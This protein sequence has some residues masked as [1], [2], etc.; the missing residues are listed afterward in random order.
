MPFSRLPPPP[1]PPPSPLTHRQA[2]HELAR[3]LKNMFYLLYH[4]IISHITGLWHL[5]FRVQIIQLL[6]LLLNNHLSLLF[7]LLNPSFIL[8]LIR[9]NNVQVRSVLFH[10]PLIEPCARYYC[11]DILFRHQKQKPNPCRFHQDQP[12]LVPFVSS[13]FCSSRHH[14]GKNVYKSHFRRCSCFPCFSNQQR[15]SCCRLSK[16]ICCWE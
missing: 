7:L 13:P 12:S 15:L 16:N 1:P 3:C 2:C 4:N 9:R 6:F 5:S 8:L 11:I 14:T 10:P